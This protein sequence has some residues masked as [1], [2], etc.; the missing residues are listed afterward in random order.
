MAL[1]Y[2]CSE[3]L[4]GSEISSTT[5]GEPGGSLAFLILS[6]SRATLNGQQDFLCCG[7][8]PALA[9]EGSIVVVSS[10]SLAA[11]PVRMQMGKNKHSPHVLAPGWCGTPVSWLFHV[12]V[13]GKTHTWFQ[14]C[15]SDGPGRERPGHCGTDVKVIKHDFQLPLQWAQANPPLKSTGVFLMASA[16]LGF[17]F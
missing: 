16:G 12:F 7:P 5:D 14:F 6:G 11:V 8:Q 1:T 13:T 2:Q 15:S 9:E 4:F 17:L 10:A 3:H